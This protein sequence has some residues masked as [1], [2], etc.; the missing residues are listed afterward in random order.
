V[1]EYPSFSAPSHTFAPPPAEAMKHDARLLE[2]T[3]PPVLPPSLSSHAGRPPEV[4][5]ATDG[6]PALPGAFDLHSVDA[7]P[8]EPTWHEPPSEPS[9]W[10]V[11]QENHSPISV[12]A[13]SHSADVT[14]KNLE[15]A[16]ASWVGSGAE[17]WGYQWSAT[18]PNNPAMPHSDLPA[19]VSPT[20]DAQLQESHASVPA[21][22]LPTSPP[23]V[24][25][26]A[27]AATRRPLAD[28]FRTLGAGSDHSGTA[29]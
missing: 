21:E 19:H 15:P 6:K 11:T 1:E 9:A 23:P 26:Q 22:T 24:A 7:T 12:P 17:Q 4:A 8:S 25:R 28:M 14:T 5:S 2:D 29:R 20:K 16:S 3:T 18:G 10:H 13:D 27:S